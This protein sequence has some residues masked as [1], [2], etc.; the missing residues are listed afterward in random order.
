MDLSANESCAQRREDHELPTDCLTFITSSNSLDQH[1][2]AL[3]RVLPPEIRAI[4]FEYATAPYESS[5]PCE[6]WEPVILDFIYRPNLQARRRYSTD[7]LLTCRRAWLESRHM[8]LQ[9]AIPTMLYSRDALGILIDPFKL[10]SQDGFGVFLGLGMYILIQTSARTP[11]LTFLHTD[12]LVESFIMRNREDLREFLLNIPDDIDWEY[13]VGTLPRFLSD[14]EVCPEMLTVCIHN[15]D[16]CTGKPYKPLPSGLLASQDM[17]WITSLLKYPALPRLARLRLKMEVE[18][19]E[20][21]LLMSIVEKIQAAYPYFQRLDHFGSPIDLRLDQHVG[22]YT[23]SNPDTNLNW[24]GRTLIW[25]VTPRTPES[26]R[27]S[28][29]SSEVNS[30]V[31]SISEL[32][33]SAAENSGA[34]QDQ[35][36]QQNE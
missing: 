15:F 36:T 21:A 23:W 30:T 9:Q 33:V 29:I 31:H 17:Q 22:E 4:I 10:S 3:F 13:F 24:K 11:R 8:P 32:R 27:E 16:F 7:L 35:T 12:R 20:S 25:K 19:G 6:G 2:S 34:R 26:V 18:E 28:T 5:E 1:Q 14:K